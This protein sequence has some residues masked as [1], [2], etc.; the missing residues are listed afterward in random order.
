M[1]AVLLVAA[2]LSANP[3]P[4]RTTFSLANGTVSFTVVHKFHAMQ[5]TS[6]VMQA[7]ARVES[8][9]TLQ[10]KARIRVTTFDSG[11]AN[12]DA[13]MLEVLEPARFPE[14]ELK[15]VSPGFVMPE[16]FPARLTTPLQAELTFHGVTQKR[17][18]NVQLNFSD[19]SHVTAEAAFSISLESFH[20]DRPAL[21]FIKIDD[22][23]D[24]TCTLSF[25]R[26]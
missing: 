5:G 1:R 6:K 16:R 19:A 4:A 21:L 25:S 18:V 9:G 23:V 15:G 24:L 26:E 10:A 8:D 12:R 7:R 13:H 22:N 3:D 17:D 20:V 11:N 2:V 14:V